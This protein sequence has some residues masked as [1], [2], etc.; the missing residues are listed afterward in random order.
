MRNIATT[1]LLCLTFINLLLLSSSCSN[2]RNLKANESLL[3][4]NNIIINN[5]NNNSVE[6]NSYLL[7]RPNHRVL[8]LPIGLLLHNISHKKTDSIYQQMIYKTEKK[9][10]FISQI[11]SKKQLY[12]IVLAKHNFNKWLIQKSEP[13]AITSNEKTNASVKNLKTYFFNQGFFNATINTNTFI[14]EQKA[15]IDYIIN[16]KDQYQIGQINYLIENPLIDSIIQKNKAKSFLKE[17][18]F[19]NYSDIKNEINFINKL[20]RNNGFYHY[21]NTLISFKDIDTLN[22]K[23]I[24]PI[25][26]QIKN[27]IHKIENTNFVQTIKPMRIS[28]I[29]VV[30]DYSYENRSNELINSTTTDSIDF[31]TTNTFLHKPSRLVKSIFFKPN[32]LYSDEKIDFTREH[33]KSLKNFKFIKINH[34]EINDSLIASTILLTPLKKYNFGINTELIHSNIKAI[35]ISGS[36]NLI[37]RNLFKGS[38]IFQLATT[39]SIFNTATNLSNQNNTFN[40]WELGLDAS[41]ETPTAYF[42]GIKNIIPQEYF[43]KTKFTFGISTQKNIGLDKQKLSGIYNYKW[44]INKKHNHNFELINLQYVRNI[45]SNSYF[46]IYASEFNTAKNISKL[47]DPLYEL[48]PQN[49]IN[50]INNIPDSFISSN[51]TE[52]NQLLNIKKRESIITSNNVIPTIGYEYEFNNKEYLNDQSY[53]FLRFKIASSGNLTS[54]LIQNNSFKNIPISQYLKFDFD[55]RKFFKTSPSNT[56]AFR[57]FIGIATPTGNT[58]IPFTASYFAGG[59]NDIRAWKAYELGPGKSSTGLEFNIGNLKILNSLEYRFKIVNSFY[60]AGFIDAGNIWNLPNTK[61][62]TNDE[63]FFNLS[64]LKNIAVGS[65]MGIRYDFNFLVFR[66]DFGFKTYEPYLID[67]K[68]FQNYSLNSSVLNIG[69]NYPF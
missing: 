34:K 48:T 2:T 27:P 36:I 25:T 52:Y 62:A 8:G 50:F 7:Q 41:I 26:I 49:T 39:G 56:I 37:N 23:H 31:F 33:L 32:E 5:K 29:G 17:G 19:Y 12:N 24:T 67:K 1:V 30:T 68:W 3:V 40:A 51:P 45:N 28:K 15:Y 11:L 64:S 60:G 6:I 44:S 46:N 47:V 14:D 43:P 54:N 10:N 61:T 22:T 42:P 18:N 9:N 4:K 35:G 55:F 63:K 13:P 69:I 57:A 20:L 38:E 53:H 16:K 58:D 59:T 21:S 66:L 65:G